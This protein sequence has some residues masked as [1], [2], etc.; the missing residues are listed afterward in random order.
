M[1]CNIYI[2]DKMVQFRI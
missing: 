2:I 1:K